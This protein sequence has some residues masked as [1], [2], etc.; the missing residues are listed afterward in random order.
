MKDILCQYVC[1]SIC[2]QI[3]S[4]SGGGISGMFPS[5]N[6]VS[7]NMAI[8][9]SERSDIAVVSDLSSRP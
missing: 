5:S 4:S 3:I 6:F 7:L 2:S 8:V 9:L 1:E